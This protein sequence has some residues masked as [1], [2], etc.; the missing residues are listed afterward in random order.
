[1][2]KRGIIINNSDKEIK[3]KVHV[4]NNSNT[5]KVNISGVIGQGYGKGQECPIENHSN[6]RIL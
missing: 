4:W 5:T 2:E 3:K 6:K 1:M